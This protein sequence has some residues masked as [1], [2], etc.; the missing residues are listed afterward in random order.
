MPLTKIPFAPGIHKEG[1][2]YTAGTSWF[3]GDKIRFRKGRVE[4]IGGWV[5][6][7]DTSYKGVCRSLFDWGTAAASKYLGMGTNLKFYVE[8]GQALLDITPIRETTGLGD[9]KFTAATGSATLIVTDTAHGVVLS[10]FVTYTDAATLGGTIIADVLNQEYQV[11]K[12]TS[13]SVYEIEAKDSNGDPVLANG[14]DI[15]D[16]G[17]STVAKYQLTT[18]TNTYVS[19]TGWG[20]SP[21][22]EAPWGGASELTLGNQLR[23]YSQ[24]SFGDDLIFNP[25]A[26]GIYYFDQSEPVGTRAVDLWDLSGASNP[27][28]TALQVMVS[29][30]DRHVI[31][32]GASPLG[33]TKSALIALD[34]LLVR[35]SDQ[36]NAAD[37]T[38][39]AINSA[40]GTVLSS[41]T[42]IIGGLKTRQEILIFTDTSI[43]SMRFSGAPF[44]FQF[45]VIA[46]NVTILSPNA[47]VSA[48]DAVF[49]MDREGFYVYRG[50]V[51]RLPCTV[52]NYVFSRIDVTQVFKVFATNNPDDSEVTWFYPVGES[53]SE[54]TDYVTYNYTEDHWTI[55]T[56]ARG[57]WIQASSRTYPLATSNDTV[58]VGTNYLYSQEYQYD[59]EGAAI[60]GYAESGDIPIGDGDRLM[61]MNR[62]I[63]DF[64]LSGTTANA[65]F[66]V[67]IKG[68]DFPMAD[69]TLH[70]TTTV[71]ENTKQKHIRVRAREITFKVEN[72]GKSYG[73]T[74]GDFRV[75]MRTDGRR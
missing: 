59:A 2:Q 66:T 14:L 3:D 11:S 4:Q 70:S 73:W 54:I 72:I 52:L 9:C 24:D 34:P 74:M 18:G 63:P 28:T 58:N 19:S 26:G 65:D 44:I 21:W 7:T 5:K 10:D 16:G 33:S 55:G 15:S 45:S 27:P 1:T 36:E 71:E 29:Q 67:S 49:F 64:R 25:R 35:W 62:Y 75:Q 6:Y 50:S 13:T 40:G 57:A 31:A 30:V 17:A 23:L 60:N 41:G 53:G 56:L 32:F 61:F 46:E 47:A 38:P 51:Q 12:V 20:A 42:R 69:L 39:T 48:G 37:W 68:R 8:V 43:H 22:G